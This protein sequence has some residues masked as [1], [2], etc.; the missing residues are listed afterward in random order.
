MRQRPGLILA[1]PRSAHQAHLF[2]V[3]YLA[4]QLRGSAALAPVLLAYWSDLG[5]GRHLTGRVLPVPLLMLRLSW[6]SFWSIRCHRRAAIFWRVGNAGVFLSLSHAGFAKTGWV[7][8]SARDDGVGLHF[9]RQT[10]RA[11]PVG[12]GDVPLGTAVQGGFMFAFAIRLYPLIQEEFL[13]IQRAL[14]GARF[15]RARFVQFFSAGVLSWFRHAAVPLGLGSIRRQSGES[16][17][18]ELRGLNLPDETGQP[19]VLSATSTCGRS[20]V[21]IIISCPLV[22]LAMVGLRVTTRWLLAHASA[23]TGFLGSPTC[24]EWVEAGRK[25]EQAGFESAWVAE[26][27]IT[28]DAVTGDDRPLLGTQSMRGGSA[29]INVFTRGAA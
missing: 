5:P 17:G 19:R 7:S 20:D 24:A 25:A 2:V 8:P 16:P 27:R 22:L 13:V 15:E 28:R 29:A 21:A 23:W 4:A 3:S 26:T 6:R 10:D 12:H 1:S 18:M 11:V 9:V 14:Q